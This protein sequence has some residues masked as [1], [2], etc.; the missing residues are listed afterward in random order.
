MENLTPDLV[1][2]DLE[3]LKTAITALQGVV[4]AVPPDAFAK[5]QNFKQLSLFEKIGLGG[6]LVSSAPLV[7]QHVHELIAAIEA[8]KL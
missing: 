7:E 2:T 3:N 8:E 1:V 6:S 4:K 5:M